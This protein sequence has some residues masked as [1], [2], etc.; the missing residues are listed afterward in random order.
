[1]TQSLQNRT[2]VLKRPVSS[3]SSQIVIAEISARIRKSWPHAD[4]ATQLS[5]HDL[6]VLLPELLLMRLDRMTMAN[7]LEARE[8]FMDYR[9]AEYVLRLPFRLKV[10]HGIAKY[11]LKQAM[12]DL[13]PQP[14]VK[15]K[16][17][18]FP[19]PM[20][21][22]LQRGLAPFA[23][24]TI[25]GSSLRERELFR[26]DKV[27]DILDAHESGRSDHNLAIWSLLILSAWYDCWISR[28]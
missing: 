10:N 5:Y 19:A 8:P 1:L 25:L 13:L 17:Q 4:F 18:P 26:Y 12:R 11:V 15:R 27:Q 24:D 28:T 14:I 2:E 22:W 16:K 6:F 21:Q 9:L 20:R 3:P 7:S 23:R